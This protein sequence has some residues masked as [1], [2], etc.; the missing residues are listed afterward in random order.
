M[1]K[2][3]P[4]LILF[5]ILVLPLLIYLFLRTGTHVVQ[6]LRTVSEKIA[7][8]GGGPDSVYKAV[9]K[10]AFQSHTGNMIDHEASGV[11]P[12]SK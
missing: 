9:G 11:I 4:F 1:R 3:G 8:P 7:D 2:A 6:P 10:F 5:I 12:E